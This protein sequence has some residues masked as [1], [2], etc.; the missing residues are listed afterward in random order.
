MRLMQINVQKHLNDIF[1][2]KLGNAR[3]CSLGPAPGSPPER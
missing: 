1:D 2:D 3:A